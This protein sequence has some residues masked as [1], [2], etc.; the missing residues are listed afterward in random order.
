MENNKEKLRL[1]THIITQLILL[2]RVTSLL[3][4]YFLFFAN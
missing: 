4:H 1:L 2:V 3:A